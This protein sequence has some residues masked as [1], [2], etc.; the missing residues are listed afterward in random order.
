MT[1]KPKRKLQTFKSPNDKLVADY[2]ALCAIWRKDPVLY[3][4]QRMGVNPTKQQQ[5]MLRAIAPEGAKVTVRAGHGVGKTTC[6]AIIVWWHLECF[7]FCK[8]PCT[9][10]TASQLRLVLW[11]ELRKVLRRADERAELDSMPKLS[12]MFK[13]TQDQIE[14]TGTEWY[15]VARTAR[16]DQPDALQGF[17]ASDLDITLDDKAVQRSKS[18]GAILFLI[19]EASGVPDEIYTVA[20]GA[21]SS[22]GA[23]LIM[24][25]NPVRSTGFFADSHLDS[26]KVSSYTQLHFSVSGSPLAEPGYREGLV[27]KYGEGSNVVRVRADGEFPKQ[28]DDVL[29]SVEATET[30]LNRSPVPPDVYTKCILGVD[31]ARFGDD[32]TT[33]IVRQGR[34]IRYI[35]VRSK[36][37]TMVTAGRALEIARRFDADIHIDVIGV[38]A[39]VF[40]RLNEMQREHG[41]TV[42]AVNVADAATLR[43]QTTDKRSNA[44]PD[45]KFGKREMFPRSMKEYLWLSMKDWYDNEEPVLTSGDDCEW[46]DYAGDLAAECATVRY[47]FDSS[48]KVVVESKDS[49]KKRGLLSPDLA[50]AL[51]CTFSPNRLS[52]WERLG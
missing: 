1:T 27:R 30:A 46:R 44:L 24:V 19:E 3:A 37:D 35:E 17:H 40:D 36:E 28:D 48:G 9:A 14:V 34:A 38:G 11:S 2:A 20:E 12:D 6:L 8:I 51:A 49:M 13:I 29:I 26:R 45:D 32:R 39:G 33:Y 22:K 23:R 43:P 4:R 10:P 42:V 18:G 50:E 5:Q 15:A 47:S 41:L 7:A 25:G 21:L 16:R 31:V 52:I